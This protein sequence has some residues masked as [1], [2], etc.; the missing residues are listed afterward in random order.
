[1]MMR[2]RFGLMAWAGLAFASQ[3]PTMAAAQEPRLVGRLADGTRAQIEALLDS[4]RTGGLP[5]EPMVD[6][7]LEGAAKG[8]SGDLIVS[9]VR[10]LW[11]ELR[12]A[13]EAFG[14]QA[15]SGELGAGASA[16][17]AGATPADLEA[18]RTRREGQSLT[19]PAAMLADLVAVGV[20]SD[21]A[22]AAVL[23]LAE[24]AGDDQYIAF[25]LNVERDIALGASPAAALGVRL[26]AAAEAADFAVDGPTSS[27]AS[28]RTPRKRKP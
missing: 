25:R 8:A 11:S 10:R 28:G 3:T 15:T 13:R 17:R 5:T 27:G 20:P 1:M 26:Q 6:R 23:A 24:Y 4:A 22:I 14:D 9:A 2:V 16:L 12:T 7:A 19:V 21:T 18:L